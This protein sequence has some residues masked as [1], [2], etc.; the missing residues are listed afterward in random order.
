MGTT[1]TTNFKHENTRNTTHLSSECYGTLVEAFLLRV[2]DV[3]GY[4]PVERKIMVLLLQLVPLILAL[5][6]IMPNLIL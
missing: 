4:D 2:P 3:A 1:T 6:L 5:V